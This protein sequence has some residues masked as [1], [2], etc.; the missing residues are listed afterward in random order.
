MEVVFLLFFTQWYASRYF[1]WGGQL[2]FAIMVALIL[3][4]WAIILGVG[5]WRDRRSGAASAMDKRSTP[6]SERVD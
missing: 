3:G 4:F 6:Q 1:H 5:L 2:P